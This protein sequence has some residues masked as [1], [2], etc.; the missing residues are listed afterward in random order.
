MP[1]RKPL[2]F[3]VRSLVSAEMQSALIT[4]FALSDWELLDFADRTLFH[5][6]AV[7]AEPGDYF[8]LFHYSISNDIFICVMAN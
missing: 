2:Q 3:I 4:L 5:Q 7:K 1:S 6:A 8:F